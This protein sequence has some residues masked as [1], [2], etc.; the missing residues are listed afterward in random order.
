MRISWAS[1]QC[2]QLVQVS[3]PHHH[4]QRM[5]KDLKDIPCFDFGLETS[6]DVRPGLNDALQ[7]IDGNDKE[8]GV[9]L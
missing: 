6:S 7:S 2:P 5:A 9:M 1:G 4:Y 3:G 8:R